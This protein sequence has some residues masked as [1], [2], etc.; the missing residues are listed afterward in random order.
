MLENFLIIVQY[1]EILVVRYIFIVYEYIS[2]CVIVYIFIDCVLFMLLIVC[3]SRMR[4]VISL[5]HCS[6]VVCNV[7]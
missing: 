4:L 2:T 6:E 1:S 5:H 7:D 3:F